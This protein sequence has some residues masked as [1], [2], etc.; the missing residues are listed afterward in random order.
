MDVSGGGGASS[1]QG[2]GPPRDRPEYVY[3]QNSRIA[4]EPP[5]GKIVYNPSGTT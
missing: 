1:S 3:G 2:E 5:L 4:S